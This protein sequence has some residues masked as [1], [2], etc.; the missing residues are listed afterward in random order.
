MQNTVGQVERILEDV[1]GLAGDNTQTDPEALRECSGGFAQLAERYWVFLYDVA[2]QVLRNH[3]NAEDAVQEG[4]LRAFRAYCE[5]T[6]ERRQTLNEQ[7][8]LREIVRNTALNLSRHERKLNFMSLDASERGEHLNVVD[9]T[10]ETPEVALLREEIY[11]EF[12]DL[13]GDL[14]ALSRLFLWYRFIKSYQ[15]DRIAALVE[16]GESLK[17]IRV[18]ALRKRVSRGLEIL[19]EALVLHGISLND[20]D[21]W[22]EWSTAFDS[23]MPM[24]QTS[25]ELRQNS[26]VYLDEMACCAPKVQVRLGSST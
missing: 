8:W 14:P 18:G 26:F 12:Y 2:Y 6:E 11:E 13:I 4:L 9:T 23:P 22:T 5:Y 25:P 15:Y 17:G 10:H 19:R 16:Q 21:A 7:A 1:P 3:E 24:R 20:L